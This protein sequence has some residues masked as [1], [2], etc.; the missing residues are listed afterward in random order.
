MLSRLLAVASATAA[1]LL[2]GCQTLTPEGYV[3]PDKRDRTPI[4][5]P[6]DYCLVDPIKHQWVAEYIWVKRGNAV[7]F[8]LPEGWEYIGAG[9]EGK[10]DA[11]RAVLKCPPSNAPRIVVCTVDRNADTTVKYGYTI[12]VKDKAPYDPFVWP[13]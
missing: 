7:R 12:Y 5:C 1:L 8:W 6:D 9:I 11:D 2:T 10:T 4:S 3:P 13:R